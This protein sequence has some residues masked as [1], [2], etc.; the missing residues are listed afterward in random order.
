MDVLEADTTLGEI[1]LPTRPTLRF[2]GSIPALTEQL[3]KLMTADARIVLAAAHQGD[4]ERLA[5]VLREY[6]VP[7]RPGSRAPRAGDTMLEKPAHGRRP[8]RAGDRALAAR[9]GVVFANANLIVFGA[10]AARVERLRHHHVRVAVQ[11]LLHETRE[12]DVEVRLEDDED[13]DGGLAL[14]PSP[15]RP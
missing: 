5:T 15:R 4:V 3:K 9:V 6:E 14:I 13:G 10:N 2:H 1:E 8:A 12:A 11:H 7:Y